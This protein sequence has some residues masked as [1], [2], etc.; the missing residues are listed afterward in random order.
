MTAARLRAWGAALALLAASAPAAAADGARAVRDL[1]MS[2][3]AQRV[4]Y[5]APAAP[6]GVL[7]L[8]P[9]GSG[10]IGISPEGTLRHGEN[11]LVR[12]RDAFLAAGYAVVIPD[13][14]RP[15]AALSGKAGGSRE[16]GTAS[17]RDGGDARGGERPRR[18]G[19]RG[20]RAGAAY[21][22]IVER[23]ADFAREQ[24]HRPVF[25]VGTSQGAIAAVNGAAHLG[26]AIAGLVLV[27]SVSRRGGS[28]ETVFD[29]APQAVTA[30]VLVLANQDDACKVSP[31]A[32]AGR[33][34]AALTHAA[35]VDVVTLAGGTTAG[36][37]CSAR[38]PHGFA[39]IEA[40]AVGAIVRWLDARLPPP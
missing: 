11:F 25:L 28:A 36:P 3:R 39:G 35:R 24:A 14:V 31:A 13:A 10:N 21:G 29:A 32:D 9:G 40:E 15:L 7:V 16:E 2:G 26:D 30:A 33:I 4:L 38:A 19:L 20:L 12:S 17:P 37:D 8:L 34:A 18:R 23:L 1:D 5:L 27:S 22:E 6:R